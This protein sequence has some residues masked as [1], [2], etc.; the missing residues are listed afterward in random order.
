MIYEMDARLQRKRNVYQTA[1]RFDLPARGEL[2]D[3]YR[4]ALLNLKLLETHNRAGHYP[5]AG[6]PEF[7][8]LFGCDTAY[9]VPG[10]CQ[11]GR[12]DLAMDA[13]RALRDIMMRQCGRTPHEILPDG[14]IFHPGN[15]QETPQFV[16][17]TWRVAQI[18]GDKGDF[19]REMYPAC[20]AAMLNYLRGAFT[21][22]ASRFPDYPHGNAMVEREGMLPLKLDSVCYTWKALKS[23]VEMARLLDSGPASVFDYA[24]DIAEAD[25]WAN[26]IEL[27]FEQDWWIESEGFYAD[28]LGWDSRQQLDKHWTQVTPLE[29]GLARP[30]HAMRVL[31]AIER[32][33]LNE[34]GLPHTVGVEERVWTLP[35]AILALVAAR[36]GRRQLALRLLGQAG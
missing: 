19:L 27:S 13:L 20:R 4:C 28:S 1:A 7:P 8:N 11:A 22:A 24:R 23:L 9:S 30:D 2:D 5:I 32:D 14:S 18:I 36:A 15:S 25:A 29:V 33:W 31:D 3:A 12:S 35:T 6:L 10:L 34:R 21:R 16:I 26:R 17:A